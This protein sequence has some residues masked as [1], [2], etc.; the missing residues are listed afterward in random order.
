MAPSRGPFSEMERKIPA[1]SV[2]LVAHFLFN[3]KRSMKNRVFEYDLRRLRH[4]K[5]V[6]LEFLK[7]RFDK[8]KEGMKSQTKEELGKM[9]KE[10]GNEMA[11]LRK[12]LVKE[13]KSEVRPLGGEMWRM[14]CAE[15][16]QEIRR[17]IKRRE[18]Q[19]EEELVRRKFD[20]L[21]QDIQRWWEAYGDSQ[22]IIHDAL[23]R[24]YKKWRIRGEIFTLNKIT[25]ERTLS[26]L[27][28]KRREMQ[29]E[30]KKRVERETEAEKEIEMDRRRS[31]ERINKLEECWE[32]TKSWCAERSV[33]T[34][35]EDWNWCPEVEWKFLTQSQEGRDELTQWA[36]DYYSERWLA[37]EERNIR[38]LER[39]D[40]KAEVMT[41]RRREMIKVRNWRGDKKVLR[42]LI[43]ESIDAEK[44]SHGTRERKLDK[45][46]TGRTTREARRQRKRSWRDQT[47]SHGG[48]VA[49]TMTTAWE[50]RKRERM[51]MWEAPPP[52]PPLRW[53]V[54]SR[55]KT[56]T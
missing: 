46:V 45:E 43:E 40:T 1:L 16:D 2:T 47:E 27:Y 30:E 22:N 29:L 15:S 42:E 51:E 13:V 26:V 36:E 55:E 20:A 24:L 34:S 44:E 18:E 7:L 41:E 14:F 37:W 19:T 31:R 10:W 17:E 25:I 3:G 32:N 9:K 56:H 6:K 12:A 23:P 48:Q 53:E 11:A 35:G 38:K 4:K 28:E 21:Q 5:G 50:R 39:I 52:G 8:K 49:R 33:S 54:R